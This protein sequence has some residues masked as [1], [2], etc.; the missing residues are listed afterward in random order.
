MI[1]FRIFRITGKAKAPK[2]EVNVKD[3]ADATA[4]ITTIDRRRTGVKFIETNMEICS[5]CRRIILKEQ[6]AAH[7]EEHAQQCSVENPEA[8]KQKMCGCAA[9]RFHPFWDRVHD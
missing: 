8:H 5:A 7:Q 9:I 1:F 4:E 3:P 6:G 2:A